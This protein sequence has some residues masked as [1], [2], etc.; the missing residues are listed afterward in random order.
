MGKFSNSVSNDRFAKKKCFFF[1]ANR[2]LTTL[3]TK[4][5]FIE[6]FI[7]NLADISMMI[8]MTDD[9]FNDH[10]VNLVFL[11]PQLRSLNAGLFQMI[12]LR[13]QNHRK[14]TADWYVLNIF[15]SV[16]RHMVK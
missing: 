4:I 13:T 5:L 8:R 2:S 10:Q 7:C 9:Q 12:Y 11:V 16:F 6:W 3:F 14:M 15:D 1:S